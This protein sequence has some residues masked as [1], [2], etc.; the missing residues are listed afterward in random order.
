MAHQ[1]VGEVL[2][3][4]PTAEVVGVFVIDTDSHFLGAAIVGIHEVERDGPVR[5]GL[6]LPFGCKNAGAGAIALRRKTDVKHCLSQND[7]GFR[8]SHHL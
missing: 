4:H 8:K 2:L 7:L 1:F 3:L 6:L 5:P